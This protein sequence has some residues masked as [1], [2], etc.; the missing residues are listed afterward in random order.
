MEYIKDKQSLPIEVIS[1]VKDEVLVLKGKLASPTIR[2]QNKYLDIVNKYQEDLGKSKDIEKSYDL[3][4]KFYKDS[5]DVLC[6]YD[7]VFKDDKKMSDAPDL[8]FFSSE[9]LE[10]VRVQFYQ[11]LFLNTSKVLQ[12]LLQD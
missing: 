11:S 8:D 5:F 6:N 9:D 7:G 12:M 3:T 10:F 1:S 4:A 2:K